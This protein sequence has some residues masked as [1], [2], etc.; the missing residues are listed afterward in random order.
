[1]SGGRCES[2][3]AF[4]GQEH[5]TRCPHSAKEPVSK[6]R[7]PGCGVTPGRAHA[8]DCPKMAANLEL[9]KKRAEYD[10]LQE[11]GKKAPTLVNKLPEGLLGMRADCIFV[12]DEFDSIPD[13]AS[14]PTTDVAWTEQ[15][16]LRRAEMEDPIISAADILRAGAGHI[17]DRAAQRDSPGGER[18]MA[19]CVHAFNAMTG[20][21]LT[22]ADG[23]LFMVYLKHA[24]SLNGGKLQPDDYEDAAAYEALRG[25][26]LLNEAARSPQ[27]SEKK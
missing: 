19:R 16:D 18:S 17:E 15:A 2:C 25:E 1:M 8:K 4:P 23:W 24:R 6:L 12:D 13:E 27:R 7:C 26:E 20:H 22:V 10:P 21:Q 5:D 14:H 9:L 3:G 11:K